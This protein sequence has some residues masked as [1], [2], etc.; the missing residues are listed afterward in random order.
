MTYLYTENKIQKINIHYIGISLREPYLLNIIGNYFYCLGL[1]LLYAYLT[2][3]F[4][5]NASDSYSYVNRFD[6]F[7][8]DSILSNRFN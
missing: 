1:G 5:L 6:C 7:G 4:Y 3:G 8:R 2:P